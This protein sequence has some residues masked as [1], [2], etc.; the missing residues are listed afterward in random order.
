MEQTARATPE[1]RLI[2]AV[3]AELRR[4]GKQGLAKGERR[5]SRGLDVFLDAVQ[6][7][8]S[9]DELVD[10]FIKWRE[11]PDVLT[12]PAATDEVVEV[13]DETDR[14]RAQ[15]ISLRVAERASELAEVK[16]FRRRHLPSGLIPWVDLERWLCDRPEPL[17]RV[18]RVLM[19]PLAAEL[20]MS[21][22][23]VGHQ[24][25]LQAPTHGIVQSLDRDSVHIVRPDG[26]WSNVD[27]RTGPIADADLLV[28][29]LVNC[30][31]WNR[32]QAFV[33]LFT[34]EVPELPLLRARQWKA[35][36]DPSPWRLQITADADLDPREVAGAF[37]AAR[38]RVA[39]KRRP[40]MTS[41]AWDATA[42]CLRHPSGT[43]KERMRSFN[44]ASPDDAFSDWRRFASTV[45]ATSARLPLRYSWSGRL[46]GTP[47]SKEEG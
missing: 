10:D 28:D 40:T 25:G 36:F 41:R 24:A 26:T 43:W 47:L 12:I 18:T 42:W 5:V 3:D 20:A 33:W 31:S 1:A 11:E 4:R 44:A 6:M 21:G 34:G 2:R 30:T 15:A 17:A 45:R 37:R 9:A 8:R 13:S 38:R 27:L 23:D 35:P 39:G 19:D 29:G 16:G 22:G 32:L 46:S 7:G 14:A